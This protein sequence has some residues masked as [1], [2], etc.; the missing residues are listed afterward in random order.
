MHSLTMLRSGRAAF[1]LS[2]ADAALTW[3]GSG[4]AP[5]LARQTRWGYFF[6]GISDGAEPSV[7]SACSL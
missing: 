4:Q 6:L 7:A 2:T 5:A 3:R 1:E